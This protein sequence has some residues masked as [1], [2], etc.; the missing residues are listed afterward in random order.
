MTKQDVQL[1][2]EVIAALKDVDIPTG[3]SIN[4]NVDSNGS[5]DLSINIFRV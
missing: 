5:N 3:V 2:K 1:A 4:I